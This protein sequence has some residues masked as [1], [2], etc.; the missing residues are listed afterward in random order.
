MLIS[1]D[2]GRRL[3]HGVDDEKGH[4]YAHPKEGTEAEDEAGRTQEVLATGTTMRK[5]GFMVNKLLL[6]CGSILSSA[7]AIL[8]VGTKL[9]EMKIHVCSGPKATHM[10][11]LCPTHLPSKCWAP[12]DP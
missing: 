7:A 11:C 2:V 12:G 10:H 5:T 6:K 9:E 4:P 3:D 8:E 1:G